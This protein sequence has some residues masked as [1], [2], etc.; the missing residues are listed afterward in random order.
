MLAIGLHVALNTRYCAKKRLH[1]LQKQIITLTHSD[2]NSGGWG[3]SLMLHPVIKMTLPSLAPIFDELQF[4]Y[5]YHILAVISA[6]LINTL[7]IG[8]VLM[9][10][11]LRYV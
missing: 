11:R 10:A 2:E 4:Y 9:T 1:P 5:M 8:G 3:Q 7:I 6:V